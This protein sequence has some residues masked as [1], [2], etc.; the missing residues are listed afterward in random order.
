MAN[1]ILIFVGGIIGGIIVG[2]IIIPKSNTSQEF[3][4]YDVNQ[5][6]KVTPLDAAIVIDY[7][8]RHPELNEREE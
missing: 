5:D 6:G 7:L 8:N 4:K 2:A 3:H 1:K